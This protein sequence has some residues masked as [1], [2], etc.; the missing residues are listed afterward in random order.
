MPQ[1]CLPRINV[2]DFCTMHRRALLRRLGSAALLTTAG[3][4]FREGVWPDFDTS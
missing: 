2:D 3:G 1:R 4:L